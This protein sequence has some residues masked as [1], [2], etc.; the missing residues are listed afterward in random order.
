VIFDIEMTVLIVKLVVALAAAGIVAGFTPLPSRSLTRFSRL[1][2][3]FE[4]SPPSFDGF[5]KQFASSP[6]TP[7]QPVAV[8]EIVAP[9]QAVPTVVTQVI[10]VPPSE[11]ASALSGGEFAVGLG[12]GLVPYLL[13]PVIALSAVKGLIKAPKPLP[14]PVEPTTT[15]G[16]YTKSLREGLNEGIKELFSE[17]TADTELTK[18]GIKLSAGGFGVAIALTAVL[19]A[20]TSAKEES[21]VIAKKPV[22]PAAIVKVITPP[23]AAPAIPAAAP[24]APA[25]APVAPAVVAAPAVIVAPAPVAPKVDSA[26]ADKAAAE[27]A[28][29]EK[30]ASDKAVAEKAAADKSASEKAAADKSASD[31]AAADKSAS[32]K[33]AADKSASDKAAADKSASEKAAADKSASDKAAADKSASEK[34]AADKSASD[35]AAA[36]KS[37]SD[38]AASDKAAS[39]KAAA[40]KAAAEKAVAVKAVVAAPAPVEVDPT[41]VPSV[42]KGMEPEKVDFA[43]LKLLRVS[44]VTHDAHL[45]ITHVQLSNKRYLSLTQSLVYIIDIRRKTSRDHPVAGRTRQTLF[46]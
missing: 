24:A 4:F 12:L 16:A 43:A 34:A 40:D 2:M 37:A 10:S 29:A 30:A 21:K 1:S 46:P 44:K 3:A 31:K 19:F 11:P 14:V 18:K 27:K 25:A 23:A 45:P 17:Q 6:A 42:P 41:Y 13:I 26:V 8:I 32:E 15:V 39:D 22:A 5:L 38:K 28:V 9:I 33:A 7:E 35:K 36:D 20:T